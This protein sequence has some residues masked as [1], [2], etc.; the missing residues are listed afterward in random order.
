MK[1]CVIVGLEFCVIVGLDPTIYKGQSYAD[2]P[3]K[4]GNDTLRKGVRRS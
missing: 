4:P 1:C 3:V 2:S